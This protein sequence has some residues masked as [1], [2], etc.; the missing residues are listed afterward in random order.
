MTQAKLHP[1]TIDC[2]YVSGMNINSANTSI[3]RSQFSQTLANQYGTTSQ[4]AIGSNNYTLITLSP[5]LSALKGPATYG[6]A[7]MS[8]YTIQQT[9]DVS[10]PILKLSSYY[11]QYVA[12]N[13]SALYGS[14]GTSIASSVFVWASEIMLTLEGPA[15]IAS[16][17]VHIGFFPLAVLQNAGT[18]S[19]NQL[20][21]AVSATLDVKETT[22]FRLTNAVVN[23]DLVT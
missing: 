18:L 4:A 13:L 9:D 23:H 2:A 21:N 12:L 22:S 3:V 19:I 10:A 6:N 17:A 20:R 8:G 5:T 7:I 14:N 16:G 15:A 11:D 1:G